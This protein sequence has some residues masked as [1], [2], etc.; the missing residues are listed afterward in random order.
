VPIPE[1][2]KF[3]KP[4]GQNPYRIKGT[5][6]VGHL[7]YVKEIVRGGVP[8]MLEA[9]VDPTLVAFFQQQFLA[10]SYY[11]IYPLVAAGYACARVVGSTFDSF[12]RVRSRYQANR[13]V[14]G[15]Y[16]M[17]IKVTSP[18]ALATRLPRLV[19][20]YFDFGRAEAHRVAP[21]HIVSVQTGTPHSM[22]R[23][24]QLV[25]ETYILQLMPMAGAKNVLFRPVPPRSDSTKDG[26]ELCE[27]RGDVF[28]DED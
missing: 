24:F 3:P 8:A 21:R 28:W 19:G 11:D 12:I 22:A 7:S 5:A 25:H 18:E 17:L 13:D 14:Q 1:Y 23:W 6:Y 2:E 20:Q 9:M 16:K 26:V 15:I 27:I 4:A 10:A